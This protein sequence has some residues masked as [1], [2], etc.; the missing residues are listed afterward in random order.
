MFKSVLHPCI[1]FALIV[2]FAS[3]LPGCGGES[4]VLEEGD[5]NAGTAFPQFSKPIPPEVLISTQM[6]QPV[7]PAQII[8][9]C[10]EWRG[11]RIGG[12]PVPMT[13][14]LGDADCDCDDD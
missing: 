14:P 1:G 7:L 5:T 9:C 2:W 11:H 13:G 4:P 12:K 10:H 8:R 6:T 3:T